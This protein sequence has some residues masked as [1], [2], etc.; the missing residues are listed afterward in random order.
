MLGEARRGRSWWVV[1]VLVVALLGTAAGYQAG[2]R[3]RSPQDV[4]ANTKPPPPTALFAEVRTGS[5]RRSAEFTGSVSWRQEHRVELQPN[6]SG[7]RQLV[8]RRSL[9]VG[10]GF[11]AGTVLVEVADRPVIALPGPVPLLRDLGPGDRGPD[12]K[13]LQTALREAGIYS[14]SVDGVFGPQTGAAL[15][16]LYDAAGYPAPTASGRGNTPQ[17]AATQAELVFLPNLPATVLEYPVRVG[18]EVGD[19]AAS[20]GSAG[21]QIELTATADWAPLLRRSARSAE[22]EIRLPSGARRSGRVLDVAST[23]M[24]DGERL[25]DV[26]VG[27]EGRL[28]ANL[29]GDELRVQLVD[30]AGPRGLKVPI[31]AVFASASLGDFV[32][33]ALPDGETES[34]PVRIIGTGDGVAIVRSAEPGRLS[35]GDRVAIGIAP[36]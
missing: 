26:V 10:V 29:A 14:A 32:R 4:V 21:L 2:S 12:V 3:I 20:V 9:A 15:T 7:A 17:V 31:S 8:T 28:P 23:R 36:P 6:Q 18:H 16:E 25:V 19:F 1:C 13:R 34:V 11:D 5:L 33:R 22:V 24:V 27:A 30:R 35:K